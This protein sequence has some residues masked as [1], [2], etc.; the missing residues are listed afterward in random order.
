VI[1][2]GKK[3]PNVKFLKIYKYNSASPLCAC[4]VSW[5]K[6]VTSLGCEVFFYFFGHQTLLFAQA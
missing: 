4:K 5:K 2:G 6:I 1:P 3:V